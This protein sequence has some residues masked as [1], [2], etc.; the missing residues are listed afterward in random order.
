MPKFEKGNHWWEQRS[1]HGRDLIF[2]SP[3][4]LWEACKEY[5]EYTAERVWVKK[6]WVGKDA[7]EVDREVSP[8]FTLNGLHIFLDIGRTTWDEY[9]QRPDFTAVTTRVETIIFNQKFEGASV[10]AYNANIIAR[11]LGLADKRE[12]TKTIFKVTTSGNSD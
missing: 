6:D 2:A 4:I 1:K 7:L 9:R 5:F 10:G 12:N 8:P 11:E 3:D